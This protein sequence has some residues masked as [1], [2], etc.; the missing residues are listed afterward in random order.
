MR[1]L[2]LLVLL[3]AQASA[4]EGRVIQ[5]ART[6]AWKAITKGQGSGVSI[7]I[8]DKGKLVYSEG[9]GV[10]DRASNAPVDAHT[11]FNIGSTSKMFPVVSVLLLVDEGKVSLDD[12]LVKYV[13][14]FRMRDERYRDISVRMLLNH[15]SGLPGS[16]FFMT[17]A[18]EL[19]YQKVVLETLAR[20]HLKHAP[21]AD[22]MYCNDGFTLAEILVERVSGQKFPDFVEQRIFQPLGMRDTGLSLGELAPDLNRAEVYDR[23]TGKKLPPEVV[24][25]HGAGGFSSTAEDLCRFGNSFTPFG[26]AI[27]SPKSLQFVRSAERTP[28]GKHLRNRPA[29]MSTGWDYSNL[30]PYE[31]RGVQVMAKGGNT[32]LY[33][34]NLE[35]VPDQ[36]LVV[37][38][39]ISG[40]VLGDSLTLPVLA[41]LLDQAA[42]VPPVARSLPWQL[43]PKDFQ[44]YEG[45]YVSQTY[46]VT[47]RLS[48]DRKTFEFVPQTGSPQSL[49]YYQGLLYDPVKKLVLYPATI[50]GNQYFFT[51]SGGPESGWPTT[52]FGC[53][54]L[55]YQKVKK[56]EHPLSLFAGQRKPWLIRN[57]PAST[58]QLDLEL[59]VTPVAY[60][61]LPGYVD[62]AGLKKVESPSYASVVGTH[63]RDQ[64]ELEL[65]DSDWA[66]VSNRLYS[67]SAPG[68]GTSATIGPKGYN[69]WLELQQDSLVRPVLP[70]GGRVIVVT[71]A[72]EQ[73]FDS[74]VDGAEFFAP[75]G[76]LVLCAG[77]VGSV[78]TLSVK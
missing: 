70:A 75:K 59:V 31:A 58:I 66:R 7:A 29:F 17:Y 44:R 20:E 67:Y 65:L 33:S 78:F 32:A 19:D 42:L 36:G 47:G 21:G 18:P 50:D 39:L 56:V 43:F 25:V 49:H 14:E 12:P 4:Q 8:M 6:T 57:L 48:R 73:L 55:A 27:L 52:P 63:F 24:E 11:R 28:F 40:S 46:C 41:E 10:R 71:P 34:G 9:L 2:L 13:P 68:S 69:E 60:K 45:T 51:T 16:S 3:Y 38:L 61:G 30:H 54:W 62:F 5:T 37:A 26:K 1:K 77:P 72:G 35:V 53:D 23:K 76:S 22:S 15:S 74:V 64:T